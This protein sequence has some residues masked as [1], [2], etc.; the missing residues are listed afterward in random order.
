VSLPEPP[1][2]TEPMS[3]DAARV[4]TYVFPPIKNFTI[5]QPE[6]RR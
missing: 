2:F 1:G 3:P 6:A 5:E 4:D